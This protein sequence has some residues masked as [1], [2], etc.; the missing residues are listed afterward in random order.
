M[1][2]ISIIVSVYNV[3][4]YIERCIH[5][6]LCQ[7]YPE[8]EIILIDDGSSDRS[9]EICDA[10]AC[11]KDKI[12]VIHQA[13]KGVSAA[14]NIGLQNVKG[15]Y[16][17][18][19]D[20]DDWVLPTYVEELYKLLVENRAE[21]A[22]VGIRYQN[23]IYSEKKGYRDRM[24]NLMSCVMNSGETLD[25]ILDE[26][27]YLGYV[28]NKIFVR[29]II[30]KNKLEFDINVTI[31]EDLL[32]CC[33]YILHI[34]KAAFCGKKLYIYNIRHNSATHSY[35][36]MT[37]NNKLLAIKKVLELC[38]KESA[39]L[40]DH[41][42]AIYVS[43][44][45]HIISGIFVNRLYNSRIITEKVCE[46]KPY[47]KTKGVTRKSRLYYLGLKYIPRLCYL[48]Y[49]IKNFSPINGR[50]SKSDG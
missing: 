23:G 16:I 14:R 5:S 42:K 6:L 49:F 26:D 2:L 15:T 30:L 22:M 32:F 4:V 45:L 27:K 3:E 9:G 46:V 1:E 10:Y 37:E 29:D 25:R 35:N 47:I 12:Y 48:F 19:V 44:V 40:A 21:M 13:N 36:F 31:W 17:I 38:G 50:K 18:F 7:T 34:D 28:W 24:I 39:A 41:M 33:Q 43:S 20:S 8:T 11:M